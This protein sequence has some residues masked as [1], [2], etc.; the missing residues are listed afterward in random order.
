MD[1]L[2]QKC[3]SLYRVMSCSYNTVQECVPHCKCLTECQMRRLESDT[4][5][6]RGRLMQIHA[7]A[8]LCKEVSQVGLSGKSET[9]EEKWVRRPCIVCQEL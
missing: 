3:L 2:D 5:L 1:L 8:M 6:R 9:L 7:A 4:Q